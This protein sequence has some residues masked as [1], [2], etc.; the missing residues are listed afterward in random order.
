MSRLAACYSVSLSTISPD[1]RDQIVKDLTITPN[2]QDKE[3]GTFHMFGIVNNNIYMPR[4][5][6]L[7]RF[8]PPVYSDLCDGVSMREGL[9]CNITLQPEREQDKAAEACIVQLRTS[10]GYGGVLSLPCGFG[11]TET[12]LYITHH[13]GRRTLVVVNSQTVMDEWTGRITSRLPTAKIGYLVQDRIEVDGCDYVIG[14]VHSLVARNYPGIDTFGTVVI[15]EAHHMA[16]RTFSRA[17]SRIPAKHILALSATFRRSDGLVKVLHWMMGKMI[18]KAVRGPMGLIVHQIVYSGGD[19]FR[20]TSKIRDR[21]KM[22]HYGFSRAIKIIDDDPDRRSLT[23][24]LTLCALANP[25][26]Q[27]AV[28][29]KQH[30]ALHLFRTSL[31]EAGFRA[32][33]I[34]FFTGVTKPEQRVISKTKRVILVTQNMGREGL[35][36]SSLN[37]LIMLHSCSD[38]EQIT[39]R[40]LRKMASS[41]SP[42]SPLVIDI[43]DQFLHYE[44]SSWKRHRQYKTLEYSVVRTTDRIADTCVDYRSIL[45]QSHIIS[46]DICREITDMTGRIYASSKLN[47]IWK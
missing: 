27:I 1:V 14:M 40:I 18:Y 24:K 41:F 28:F 5:Y 33:Q 36:I 15:D 19:Y 29:A 7:E 38:M 30:S 8:G 26:R 45:Q 31:I 34:G 12:A 17:L 11:K 42:C 39:G 4:Y 47:E 35:D 9:Q 43:V 6:G 23:V 25:Y 44:G 20:S 2:P 22:N 3:P 13:I 16:A 21:L 32:S 46:D 10:P 37:T